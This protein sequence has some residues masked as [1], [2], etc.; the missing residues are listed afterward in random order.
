MRRFELAGIGPTG[1]L[2]AV[3]SVSITYTELA[4]SRQGSESG[5]IAR[6]GIGTRSAPIRSAK[7]MIRQGRSDQRR[8]GPVPPAANVPWGHG[9]A[10]GRVCHRPAP[11]VDLLANSSI[12]NAISLSSASS[13]SMRSWESEP[14]PSFLAG[15]RIPRVSWTRDP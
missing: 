6:P 4:A 10:P 15:G 12:L 8:Q 9:H 13:W 11:R 1:S 14:R 7:R 3:G 5:R 2:G